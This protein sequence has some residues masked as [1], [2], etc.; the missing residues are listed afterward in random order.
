MHAVRHWL[1]FIV[2]LII[3]AL[4]LLPLIGKSDLIPFYDTVPIIVLA[5]IV[6]FGGLYIIVDSIFEMIFHT[7]TGIITMIVGLVVAAVGTVVVLSEH[8]ILAFKIPF[9]HAVIFYVLFILEGLFLMIAMF[10]MD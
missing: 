9:L 7:Q 6:A 8:G 2:G 5:F 1:S 3:F 10:V 4:G